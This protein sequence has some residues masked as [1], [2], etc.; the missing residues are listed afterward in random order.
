MKIHVNRVPAEGLEDHATYDPRS[1]DMEREDIHLDGPFEIDARVTKADRQLIVQAQIRCALT[2]SCARC[3]ADFA[4]AINMDAV[5][6]YA[7]RPGQVVDITDDLRQEV[8][9]AYPMIPVCQPDCK[10]LCASC[11]V[12]LNRSACDH[13]A[14]PP[15]S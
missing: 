6:N 2:L 12:N 9:L 11:G 10:G 4:S 3:L 5:F 13:Q 14:H 7:V 1:L 15:S 8:I